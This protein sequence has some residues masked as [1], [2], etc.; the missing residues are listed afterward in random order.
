MIFRF[1][2]PG[3]FAFVVAAHSASAF[4]GVIITDP[5]S[6]IIA[7]ELAAPSEGPCAPERSE[8]DANKGLDGNLGTSCVLESASGGGYA[9]PSSF[10]L[11]DADERSSALA[12]LRVQF[13]DRPPKSILTVPRSRSQFDCVFVF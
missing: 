5:S 11:P 2:I 4:A 7:S 12:E 1:L 3:L 9:I 8:I 6:E 13:P 10:R